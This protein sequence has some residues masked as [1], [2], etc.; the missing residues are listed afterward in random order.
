MTYEMTLNLHGNCRSLQY[1]GSH[2]NWLS[3]LWN[4][5]Q[6]L[7]KA[8]LL[9]IHMEKI[10]RHQ[11]LLLKLWDQLIFKYFWYHFF[12]HETGK[13]TMEWY[14]TKNQFIQTISFLI[15]SFCCLNL[16]K[17]HFKSNFKNLLPKKIVFVDLHISLSITCCSYK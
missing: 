1:T 11:Y 5:L 3:F 2:K 9:N 13:Q 14:L 4:E 12:W 10:S 8:V 6:R 7:I 16:L 17:N 15:A